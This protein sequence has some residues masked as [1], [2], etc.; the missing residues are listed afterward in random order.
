MVLGESLASFTLPTNTLT[1]ALLTCCE[2]R[3]PRFGFS[4]LSRQFCHPDTV[5]L[6]GH[7][8]SL[9]GMVIGAFLDPIDEISHKQR[10]SKEE[11]NHNDQLRSPKLRRRRRG[12]G[13]KFGSKRR[14][15]DFVGKPH[16]I[17]PE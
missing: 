7:S 2:G 1:V 9:A 12:H 17:D 5:A 4:H 10:Q 3:S 8:I 14:L 13:T 11:G 16:E 6:R 15:S